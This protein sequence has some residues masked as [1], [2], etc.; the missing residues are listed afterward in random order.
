MTN[1]WRMSHGSDN[2][3]SDETHKWLIENGYVSIQHDP[4]HLQAQ[5]FQNE[6]KAGDIFYLMRKSAVILLGKFLDQVIIREGDLK[7]ENRPPINEV[8]SLRR[9]STL[10][11]LPEPVPS[12]KLAYPEGRLIQEGWAPSGRNTVFQV[13]IDC[14]KQFQDLVLEPVF[15]KKIADLLLEI[16]MQDKKILLESHKQI[17]LQG[18]PGTGKTRLALELT[19][20]ILG[21]D[22]EKQGDDRRWNIV[23]F[24]PSYNYED[25]VRGIRVS[26]SPDGKSVTYKT[27]NGILGEMAAKA[28]KEPSQPY[29]LIIDEINRANLASVLGE[30]IYA[31]EYRGKDVETPYLMVEGENASRKISLPE[32][33]LIIGTMNT[34]D[35]SIGHIDYAIR[36]RFAFVHCPPEKSALAGYYIG[37]DSEPELDPTATL[38]FDAVSALFVGAGKK[39]SQDFDASDVQ[40]G[41]SYFLAENM[42]DLR[43]KLNYQ[44]KP[45]LREYLRDGVLRSEAAA[46]IEKLSC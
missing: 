8:A 25:F 6:I 36:R 14:L 13:P 23:Q 37:K 31:L 1:F 27:K 20:G 16:E 10:E 4:E 29:I 35:R 44:V 5:R 21:S 34:A 38:L 3:M 11:L 28:A 12:G 45:I 18:P 7:E 19:K 40:L 41:H 30:L 17:I 2:D 9:F 39:L 46:D 24:H 43:R 42:E 15:E 22:Y 32:N 33:L 26:T